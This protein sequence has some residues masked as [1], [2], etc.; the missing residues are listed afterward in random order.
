MFALLATRGPADSDG[1]L[2]LFPVIVVIGVLIAIGAANSPKEV[3]GRLRRFAEE[4]QGSFI[5]GRNYELGSIRLVIRGLTARMTFVD[6]KSSSTSLEVRLQRPVEGSLTI[7]PNAAGRNFLGFVG[8]DYKGVGDRRFDGSYIV[9]S[10]PESLTGRIF[11]PDRREDVIRTVRLLN[12]CPG[13]LLR[14]EPGRL[15]V[16][17]SECLRDSLQVLKLRRTV[18]E[19]LGYV[20]SMPEPGIEWGESVEQLTGRCPICAQGLREPLI[21][22]DR[23]RAPHHRDCWEYLGR[24]AVFGCDPKPRRRAA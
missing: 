2:I 4:L 11:A 19:F 13:Y 24:C 3:E 5:P 17:V 7:R 23:C 21:R 15:I 12:G 1:A 22:C 6:G 9:T 14:L 18:E 16:Q 20:M 10:S 8:S